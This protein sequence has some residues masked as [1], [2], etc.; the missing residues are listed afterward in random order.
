MPVGEQVQ[1]IR[2]ADEE[3]EKERH[4]MGGL[5]RHSAALNAAV[6]IGAVLSVINAHQMQNGVSC[7][8]FLLADPL[9]V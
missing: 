1:P 7:C 5:N 4:R 2:L 9:N 8:F 3:V 6:P